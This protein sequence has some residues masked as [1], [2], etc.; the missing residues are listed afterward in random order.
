ML[1][2]R[3]GSYKIYPSTGV[4]LHEDRRQKYTRLSKQEQIVESPIM[5]YGGCMSIAGEG[6]G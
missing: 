5:H 6:G 2:I 1:Q 4:Q 3:F